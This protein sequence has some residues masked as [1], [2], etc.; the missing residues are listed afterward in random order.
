MKFTMPAEFEEHSATIMIWC[1]RQGSWS[2]QA[3]YARPVFKELISNICRGELLFLA[4]STLSK[5][6][7]IEF[8]ND[9]IESGKVKLLDIETNDCWARDTAPTFVRT[10][11][12]LKGVDWAFNAW[13]GDF[14]GL[15]SDYDLDDK[16]AEELLKK[17]DMPRIDAKDFVLEGG[18]I[19]SNGDG[20][21]LTTE[22]CLLSKGRNP[23]L[24]KSEIEQRLKFFLG[25]ERIVWLPKGIC[26]DETNGHIDN[27]CAFTAKNR[28]VLAWTDEGE[29]GDICRQN[30]QILEAA[31]LEVVP[32]PLPKRAVKITQFDLDGL[33]AA[34][35]EDM[36]TLGEQ[37]AASYVNFYIS[38]KVVIVPQFGDENDALAVNIL[39]EEFKDREVVGLNAREIIVGGG[40]FHCLTQQIPKV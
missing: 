5:S 37:L 7:A 22:E 19:H 36:R 35:G 14:D 18:S 8:L 2:Y 27:I 9:E 26:G 12:G 13:G 15:Y 1:E 11:D 25:A 34:E 3:K 24:K 31:G 40:N 30:R 21:I 23:Q 32:L 16:F 10:K 33:V 38:N 28:V 6:S 17:I 29:Q 39:K 20:L 4:V